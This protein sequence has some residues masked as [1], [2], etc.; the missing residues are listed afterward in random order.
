MGTI[1][2]NPLLT[3]LIV[4]IVIFNLL[5]IFRDPLMRAM[6]RTLDVYSKCPEDTLYCDVSTLTSADD[7]ILG[8]FA[9]SFLASA[10]TA[11]IL[12]SRKIEKSWNKRSERAERKK[13]RPRQPRIH[14]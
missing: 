8:L 3:F 11:A 1:R 9:L 7:I 5:F 12:L 14:Q 13:P 6:Y 4:N 10:V 2:K